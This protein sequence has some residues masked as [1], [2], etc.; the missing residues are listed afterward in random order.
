MIESTLAPRR[1]E[2]TVL[3]TTKRSMISNNL[4][5]LVT[6]LIAKE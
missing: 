6:A 5:H 3:S 2:P 1:S 4:L